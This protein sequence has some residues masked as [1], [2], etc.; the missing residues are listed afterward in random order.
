MLKLKSY[1][2]CI[3]DCIL[4][5]NVLICKEHHIYRMHPMQDDYLWL[6]NEDI[7]LLTNKYRNNISEINSTYDLNNGQCDTKYWKDTSSFQESLYMLYSYLTHML[8]CPPNNELLHTDYVQNSNIILK[9]LC[10]RGIYTISGNEPNKCIS[11]SHN[12]IVCINDNIQ[13]EFVK[14]LKT[15]YYRGVNV[16]TQKVKNGKTIQTYVFALD[17][18][19]FVYT[20]EVQQD[21]K[22]PN[23]FHSL[24]L[25]F[26]T[27]K[28]Y[29]EICKEMVDPYFGISG[30]CS[31]SGKTTDNMY[32]HYAKE[33]ELSKS[34]SLFYVETWS[35]TYDDF[36][37]EDVLFQ[38]W[39]EF[40]S[41]YGH[42]NNIHIDL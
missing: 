2:N 15:L 21:M 25:D 27:N 36:R 18:G 38:L 1:Y 42:M 7:E 24:T 34:H 39:L 33:K 31:C 8:W 37:V 16:S 13:D 35:Q 11:S 20:E 3:K 6:S 29:S 32:I 9:E 40:N 30:I 17:K 5:Q 28:H 12:F 4:Q 19:I 10:K 26:D 22:L 23:G 41:K 14:L